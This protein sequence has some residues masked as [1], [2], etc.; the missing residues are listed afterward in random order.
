[1]R[2]WSGAGAVVDR[3]AD[4]DGDSPY[5]HA[6]GV[7]TVRRAV[8]G[9]YRLVRG[10]RDLA[11]LFAAEVD[12]LCWHQGAQLARVLGGPDW[13]AAEGV[14]EAYLPLVVP[15]EHYHRA[16]FYLVRAVDEQVS[17]R[18]AVVAVALALGARQCRIIG[19][20]AAS[21]AAA[22]MAMEGAG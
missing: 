1:M 3:A 16:G 15:A 17:C 4:G 6:G 8:S 2:H 14:S 19:G 11:R 22:V 12:A 9:F 10:D 20:L 7:A 13:Y 21:R 5:A 18:P